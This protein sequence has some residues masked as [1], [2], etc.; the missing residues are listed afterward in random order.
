M[1]LTLYRIG[2]SRYP[3]FDGEGAKRVGGRWNSPGRAV[4]YCSANLSCCRLEIMAHAGTV[5]PPGNRSWVQVEVAPD[6]HVAG[7]EAADLPSGWNAVGFEQLEYRA[8]RSVGDV[9]LATRQSL[10]L[11]VPSVASQ[12]DHVYLV[13]PDHPDFARLSPTEPQ[14]VDWDARLFHFRA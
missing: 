7:K 1:A 2:A 14:A 4:I 5:R 6:I 13:N 3:V 9:W 8:S 11:R 12:G 10:I